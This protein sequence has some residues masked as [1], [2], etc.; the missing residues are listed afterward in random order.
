MA[1]VLVWIILTS[2][3]NALLNTLATN[4]RLLYHRVLHLLAK[5][6]RRVLSLETLALHA[7]VKSAIQDPTATLLFLILVIHHL[8]KI[9]ANV[10]A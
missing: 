9:L 10:L 7:N 8:A 6:E 3:A 1:V 4:V 2:S 5:T